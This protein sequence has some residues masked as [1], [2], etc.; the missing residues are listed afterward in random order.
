[1][2][3][4]Y[5]I[6]AFSA[7]REG[8]AKARTFQPRT[9]CRQITL[10]RRSLGHPSP[11]PDARA[12]MNEIPEQT[13]QPP[14]TGP[15]SGRETTPRAASASQSLGSI[16][17]ENCDAV[18]DDVQQARQAAADLEKQLAGKSREMLHLKYLFDRTKDHLNHLQDNLTQLR[19]ERHKLANDAMRAQGLEMMLARVTA[20]RDRLKSDWRPSSTASPQRITGRSCVSTNGTR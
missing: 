20:E 5:R 12:V 2:H 1:M 17:G 3:E 19:K 16:V 14:E 8:V 18:Q 6:D 4:V 7:R 11:G 9:V 15:L 13:S 10:A